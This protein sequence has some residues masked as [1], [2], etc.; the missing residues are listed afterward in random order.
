MTATERL[1]QIKAARRA[2]LEA[3]AE[4]VRQ[5]AEAERQQRE[6]EMNASVASYLA[7]NNAE[8]LMQFYAGSITQSDHEHLARF[9][10]PDHA[11]IEVAFANH[12]DGRW[13]PIAYSH[14]VWGVAGN[15]YLR[16]DD[17]LLA[18]EARGEIPF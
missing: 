4:Q 16:L 12:G 14:G 5:K 9:K 6:Q 2:E 17:A 3:A 13:A 10:I 7:E 8:W 15:R 1:E 18:A 11:T